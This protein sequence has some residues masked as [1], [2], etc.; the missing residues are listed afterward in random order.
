MSIPLLAQAVMAMGLSRPDNSRARPSSLL[1]RDDDYQK[2]FS[3]NLPLEVF[4]WLAQSQKAVDAFLLSE[5]AGGDCP[6]AYKPALSPRHGRGSSTHGQ[7]GTEPLIA[8]RHR[9]G[10]P[11]HHRR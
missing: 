10:Q 5:G 8:A 1:K 4:L 2:I 3:A 9:T 11:G 6:G 7:Q